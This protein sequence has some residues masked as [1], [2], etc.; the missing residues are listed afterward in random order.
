VLE[1]D[2]GPDTHDGGPPW[3]LPGTYPRYA[4]QSRFDLN[5]EGA[6]TPPSSELVDR[7]DRLV[8]ALDAVIRRRRP[9][10]SGNVELRRHALGWERFKTLV[11]RLD[12]AV[13]QPC[14]APMPSSAIMSIGW[15]SG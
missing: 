7:I 13:E 10:N 3:E 2:D 11:D 8:A 6:V 14:E 5:E 9:P 12:A 1:H 15:R 4:A